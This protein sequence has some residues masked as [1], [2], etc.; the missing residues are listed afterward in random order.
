MIITSSIIVT[1]LA[2]MELV[3]RGVDVSEPFHFGPRD[4]RPE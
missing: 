3:E 4:R 1:K 2:R